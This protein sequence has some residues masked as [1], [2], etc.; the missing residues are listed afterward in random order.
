M[1]EELACAEAGV[2][3]QRIGI[4]LNHQLGG[5]LG[6][7]QLN[8]T[9]V[10]EYGPVNESKLLSNQFHLEIEGVSDGQ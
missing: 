6:V 1:L 5:Q 8:I 2:D 7:D 4:A 3:P 9:D 10:P